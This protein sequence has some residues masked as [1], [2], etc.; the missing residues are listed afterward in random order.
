MQAKAPAE[1]DVEALLCGF[2]TTSNR[3]W[4]NESWII[5]VNN[6]WLNYASVNSK[7][8]HPPPPGRPP[9]FCTLLLPRGQDLYLMTLPGG[10][11]F[12]YP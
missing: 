9:G 2:E 1:R 8:Q 12:A 6:P 10:R 5:H 7:H 3:S 4:P 11:V